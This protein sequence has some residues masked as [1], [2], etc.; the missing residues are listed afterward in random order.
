MFKDCGIIYV[1]CDIYLY[2]ENLFMPIYLFLHEAKWVTNK[3]NPIKS[4]SQTYKQKSSR[5]QNRCL[6]RSN[7]EYRKLSTVVEDMTIIIC[8]KGWK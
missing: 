5:R 1:P 3:R 8:Q 7:W 4:T 2:V 6:N